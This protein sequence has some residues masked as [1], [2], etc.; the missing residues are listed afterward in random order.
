[1]SITVLAGATVVTMDPAR[2]VLTAGAVAFTDA[3]V[4]V[5]VGDTASVSADHPGA[6]VVDCAGQLI[7][8]GFVNTHTHLF[9]TLLKGLGDDRVLSDWFTS[10]TGPSAV[11][12]TPEDCYAGALHGCAEALT[13]GTTTLLDFM[14]VHP[15]RTLGDAVAQAMAD[16]GIRGVM[17][18]GYMT[19][20]ADVGV[21][22]ELVQPLDDALLDAE[23]LIG[24]WNRP[25]SRVTVGLAP[26]MS[27][28]VD[29]ETLVQTRALADATG[30]LVT[31]HL[32]E[33]PFDVEESLRRFGSRDVPFA[34]ETGLLGPDLLAAHCVQVDDADLDLLAATGTKVSH[35]P[36]SNL[37]LGSGFAPVPAMQ[38]RGITV[39]L[40]SDGPASSSNH[41]MLQ[42][43]KFAALL[44]KGVHRDPEIMTAEKALEMATIDGAQ[45]LGMADSIGSLE[46]GKRADVVVLD[47]SNLCVTPVHAAVSSLVYSQRGDEVS[48]VYVDGRLVVSDGS[49]VTVPEADVR[50]R[51]SAAA[52]GLAARAGT[53][54]FATRPWRSMV[55]T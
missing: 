16:V 9:Q 42:A 55:G 28:S 21:P 35:N 19:A 11:Q 18:R 37:Y 53:D 49:L 17:A 5:A 8:P 30:A 20:G 54:R 44:H 10:M 6:T 33:S 13:T 40:A 31:M 50:A 32:S 45:A 4:I 43:M 22:P 1:M 2:R 12:L 27:W 3:G 23:R 7:V 51:S 26:C 38:R 24:V 25:D 47:M 46:V 41:S 39:G 48:R 15:R 34:A 52:A 29:R 36:C 14:Y